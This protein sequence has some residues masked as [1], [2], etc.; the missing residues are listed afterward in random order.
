MNF[1][2]LLI[3]SAITVTLMGTVL[4]VT[5]SLQRLF[6][7][8]PEVA[9]MHQRLRAGVDALTKDLLAAGSPMMPYRS[10]ARRHD[11]ASGVFYRSDTITLV[12]MAWNDAIGTSHTYYVKPDAAGSGQ[13]MRYDGKESDLPLADHVVGLEFQYLNADGALLAPAALQDG[14]WFPDNVDAN[15]FDMDLLTIRRV[16]V[17]LRVAPASAALRRLLPEREIRFDVA[18]RNLNHE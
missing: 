10:G 4:G 5:T 7:A 18:P 1:G 13:L 2:E 15:R 17:T 14:P 9:D 16:R 8:Q 3:A 6:V 11:P 12:P